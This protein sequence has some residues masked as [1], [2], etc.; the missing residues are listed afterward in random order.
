MIFPCKV[1]WEKMPQQ[2]T[3][4]YCGECKKTIRDYTASR[5]DEI[6]EE[7]FCGRFNNNQVS[8]PKSKY[9]VKNFK[10]LSLSLLALL[11]GV[12]SQDLTAQTSTANEIPGDSINKEIFKEKFSNLRFP[13]KMEGTI[14]DKISKEV[15][16]NAD[17]RML[18]RDSVLY[19]V[20]T[21]S[22]GKFSFV[23]LE[24]DI[25]DPFFDLRVSYTGTNKPYMADTLLKVPLISDTI[26]NNVV[27]S[28]DFLLTPLVIPALTADQFKMPYSGDFQLGGVV[29]YDFQR[30]IIDFNKTGVYA[31][32]TVIVEP[33]EASKASA[34]NTPLI[35]KTK[36]GSS[37]ALRSSVEEKKQQGKWEALW[38]NRTWLVVVSLLIALFAGV[39]RFRKKK[40]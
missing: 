5:L 40:D 31:L 9:E 15:V 23:L 30:P 4:K 1:D 13:L 8:Y 7:I 14:R 26:K 17:V 38:I 10:G 35:N 19:S 29:A 28:I 22:A 18:Q 32:T 11:G 34:S 16:V 36:S 39:N 25:R 33:Q 2:E 20:K 27:F 6:K 3:G 12:Q 24:K 37:I 21:D